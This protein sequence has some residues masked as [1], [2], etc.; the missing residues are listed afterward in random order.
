MKL[1][2]QVFCLIKRFS[3]C[4]SKW[5]KTNIISVLDF[6]FHLC[7][8]LL[9]VEIWEKLFQTGLHITFFN[10]ENFYQNCFTILCSLSLDFLYN[11][12]PSLRKHFS[13]PEIS[14]VQEGNYFLV[15]SKNALFEKHHGTVLEIG[16]HRTLFNKWINHT[17]P[18]VYSVHPNVL[19]S[20]TCQE[21]GFHKN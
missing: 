3:N 9:Y 19:W 8:R 10:V 18:L 15:Y 2:F 13:W 4:N 5:T 12:L 16:I 21:N 6:D 14:N 11:F 20:H 1:L 17:F 7:L